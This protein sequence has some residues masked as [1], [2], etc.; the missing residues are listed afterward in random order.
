MLLTCFII[1]RPWCSNFNT[2]LVRGSYV[3]FVF[4]LSVMLSYSNAELADLNFIYGLC[5]GYTRAS[6]REYKNRFPG[7]R[8]PALAMFSRIHQAL[9]KRGTFRWSLREGLHN[10]DLE[11]EILDEVN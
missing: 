9:R 11:R 1:C 10:T 5:N 3:V 7:R 2:L 8:V 4:V 6:Q